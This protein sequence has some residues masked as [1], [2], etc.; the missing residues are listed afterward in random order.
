[1]N[2]RKPTV[3]E[4]V[5][6]ERA[7]AGAFL[8]GLGDSATFGF[9]DEIWAPIE[10][11][12]DTVRG[13]N[14]DGR[15]WRER[16]L[17]IQDDARANDQA[18]EAAHPGAFLGGQ[19]AGALL[20][21]SGGIVGAGGRLLL[22]GGGKYAARAL[23]NKHVKPVLE[24]AAEGA[25]GGALYGFGSGE[26]GLTDRVIN[27][28]GNSLLGAGTGAILGGAGA[29]VP[30]G[31]RRQLGQ[32]GRYFLDE[33][34]PEV[35]SNITGGYI[36]DM[37]GSSDSK[38]GSTAKS[39]PQTSGSSQ[40]PLRVQRLPMPRPGRVPVSSSEYSPGVVKVAQAILDA[41]WEAADRR[42]V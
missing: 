9:R 42:F 7:K 37:F 28:V 12:W 36:T 6:R 11:T 19:V 2:E 41:G 5:A 22:K 27:A 13:D 24:T 4:L 20:P 15:S 40:L 18:A 8:R 38:A 21:T 32:A 39:I 3:E 29:S 35:L 31:V 14:A 25:A 16:R 34:A 30:E 23:E 1:M 26:G 33:V 17:K 10:A